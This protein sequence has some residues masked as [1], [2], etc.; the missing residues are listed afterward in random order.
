M[1]LPAAGEL[2]PCGLRAAILAAWGN[3]GAARS[4]LWRSS[5]GEKYFNFCPRNWPLPTLEFL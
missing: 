4:L 5:L 3:M 2:A 1:A